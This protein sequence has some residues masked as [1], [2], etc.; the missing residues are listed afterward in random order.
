MADAPSH[1]YTGTQ[2]NAPHSVEKISGPAHLVYNPVEGVEPLYTKYVS[3]DD[4]AS[5]WKVTKLMMLGCTQGDARSLVPLA[6]SWLR[7]PKMTCAGEA[8]E[9]DVKER[10]YMLSSLSGDL[11]VEAPEENPVDGMCVIVPG[12]DK[13]PAQVMVNGASCTDYKA[14]IH[15]TWEGARLILW[16]PLKTISTTEIS[17]VPAK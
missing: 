2:Y 9:Y 8:V 11:L 16:L 13:L 17:V 4:L 15:Q 6:K 10:A 14:G 3:A 12:V 1:S 7:A 5:T